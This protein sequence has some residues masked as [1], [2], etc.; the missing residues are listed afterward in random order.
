M[1]SIKQIRIRMG[2]TQQELA[3][4]IGVSQGNVSF[5]ERGQ[6]VPPRVAERL[7]EFARSKSVHITFNDVYAATRQEIASA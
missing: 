3:A 5:Y 4:G 2:L 7:I 1:N 6:I